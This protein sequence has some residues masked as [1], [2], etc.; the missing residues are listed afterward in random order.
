MY[1]V[2]NLLGTSTELQN[3]V[4]G[5]TYYCSVKRV[6]GSIKM[7][8]STVCINSNLQSKVIISCYMRVARKGHS[9]WHLI[10]VF[11]S[12]PLQISILYLAMVRIVARGCET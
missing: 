10:S 8:S 6:H 4:E 9:W 11:R 3:N 5:V 7:P 2:F 1:R 12:P